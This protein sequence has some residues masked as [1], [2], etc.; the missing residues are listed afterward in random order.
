MRRAV[1]LILLAVGLGLLIVALR[2]ETGNSGPLSSHELPVLFAK[3]AVVVV[4]GASVLALFRQNFAQALQSALIWVVAALLFA[5]GYTYRADLAVIGR[6]VMAE[7]VP[8][9]PQSAA[10]VRPVGPSF[11]IVKGRGGEVQVPTKVNGADI[12]MVLDTGAS[13]VVLTQEAARAAGLPMVLLDYDVVVETANGRTRAAA[14]ILDRLAVGPIV[15]RKVPALIAQP[16]QL[17][18]SLLGM[19]FLSRLESWEMR[20]GKVILRGY[21]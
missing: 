9:R 15:E 18:V 11:E 13:Q 16:G 3:L 12:G 17:K 2:H 4:V 6:K 14:V 1:W 8:A 10:V 20:E 21:P 19:T 7:V 5:V